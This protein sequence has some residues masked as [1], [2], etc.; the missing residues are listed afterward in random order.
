MNE[1]ETLVEETLHY[2]YMHMAAMKGSEEGGAGGA[3]CKNFLAYF[4]RYFF[5]FLLTIDTY[6]NVQ[7]RLIFIK[8]FRE[9][10]TCYGGC[11]QVLSYHRFHA[12]AW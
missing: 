6:I 9:G 2:P 5:S 10:V 3:N 4:V 1:Y 7:Y 11:P 8:Y 12:Y